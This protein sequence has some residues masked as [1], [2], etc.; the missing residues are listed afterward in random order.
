ML[1]IILA[2]I[3]VIMPTWGFEF[4]ASG[5]IPFINLTIAG[6]TYDLFWW[7]HIDTVRTIIHWC[8]DLFGMV[9]VASTIVRLI[10]NLPLII[11][12]QYNFI[13]PSYVGSELTGIE[14]QGAYIEDISG[15]AIML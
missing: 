6:A 8:R 12:G 3:S 13:G 5:G 2:G 7:L 9:I 10:K 14:E 1:Q 15:G 11:Q 4:G